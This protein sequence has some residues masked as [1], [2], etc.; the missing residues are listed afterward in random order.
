[1]ISLSGVTMVDL[2]VLLCVGGVS[3]YRIFADTGI[4]VKNIFHT[5]VLCVTDTLGDGE[6]LY[7]VS[8]LRTF[9]RKT[10]LSVDQSNRSYDLK[11]HLSVLG[12]PRSS[13]YRD[14]CVQVSTSRLPEPTPLTVYRAVPQVP[15]PLDSG[16]TDYTNAY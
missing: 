11:K 16:M 6:P 1:M 9:V 5:Q 3:N 12:S 10:P 14:V 4:C 8:K 15:P 7:S 2:I 13:V